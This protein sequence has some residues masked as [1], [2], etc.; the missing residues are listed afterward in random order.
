MQT[1]IKTNLRKKPNMF[2]QE[3]PYFSSGF[4]G[5]FGNQTLH[6]VEQCACLAPN[7]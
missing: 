3:R 4:A 6:P 2:V 5:L 1:V 7:V